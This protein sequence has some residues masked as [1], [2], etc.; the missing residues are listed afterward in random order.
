MDPSDYEAAVLLARKHGIGTSSLIRVLLK[1]AIRSGQ[2]FTD[3]GLYLPDPET[4]EGAAEID[5]VDAEPEA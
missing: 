5:Q 3:A 4:P 1:G 2:P